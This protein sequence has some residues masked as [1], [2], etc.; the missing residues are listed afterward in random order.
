METSEQDIQHQIAALE[1]ERDHLRTQMEFR[2][3]LIR[4]SL[5]L[6]ILAAGFWAILS[7]NY[8][9]DVTNWAYAIIGT[10]VGYWLR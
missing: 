9:T 1:L 5:S 6:I 8:E 7:S 4:A 10:V 3:L 2:N